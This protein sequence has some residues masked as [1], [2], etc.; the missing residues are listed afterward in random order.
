MTTKCYACD[1]PAVGVRDRRPEGQVI[2]DACERHAQRFVGGELVTRPYLEALDR[3]VRD[4]EAGD[5]GEGNEPPRRGRVLIV[6]DDAALRRTFAR[7]LRG[8]GWRVDLADGPDEAFRQLTCAPTPDVV[9]SDWDMPGG[10]GAR[11]LELSQVPVVILTGNPDAP[12]S[13]V[14]VLCKPSELEVID[15]ELRAAM[16]GAR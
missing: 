5:P 1:A 4:A 3:A 13:T 15:A 7:C 16:R 14:R 6:D 9:L 11:V 2:E 12:P 10:G 8:M